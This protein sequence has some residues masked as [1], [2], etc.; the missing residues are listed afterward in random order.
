MSNVI[1]LPVITTLDIDPSRIL[2]KAMEADLKE[3]VVTGFTKD[4]QEYFASSVSDAAQVI[5][6]GERVKHRLMRIIDEQ[7]A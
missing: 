2:S 5:Y 1:E 4:G 6:H 3:V 7:S